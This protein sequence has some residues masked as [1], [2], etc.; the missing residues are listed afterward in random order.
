MNFKFFLFTAIL[1]G[2]LVFGSA[3][4][5]ES[6]V[7]PALPTAVAADP[8]YWGE[9]GFG[10]DVLKGFGMPLD[11]YLTP[12]V[13]ADS[14]NS[15][16]LSAYYEANPDLAAELVVP[17][18]KRAK[19]YIVHFSDGEF[20]QG[21]TV[22]SF[23]KFIAPDAFSD[24]VEFHL[25]GLPSKD[26][27]VFYEHIR[28]WFTRGTTLLKFSV[29]VDVVSLDDTI[30]QTW[31]FK[32]CSITNYAMLQ[33]DS[34]LFVSFRQAFIPEIRE[35]TSFSCDGSALHTE[36]QTNKINLENSLPTKQDSAQAFIVRFH[37]GAIPEPITFTTFSKFSHVSSQEIEIPIGKFSIPVEGKVFEGR[38]QFVLESLP[39]KDK[40]WLYQ[41]ADDW[42]SKETLTDP[43]DVDIEFVAGDGTIIQTWEYV[44]CDLLD[45]QIFSADSLLAYQFSGKV[46]TELRDISHFSCSGFDFNTEQNPSEIKSVPENP[47]NL[48]PDNAS[49]GQIYLVKISGGM[50]P[51]PHTFTTFSKFTHEYPTIENTEQPFLTKDK[52]KFTL[53]SL[54]SKDKAEFYQGINNWFTQSAPI[55]PADVQIDILAGDGTILRSYEYVKCDVVGYE[56]YLNDNF[57]AFKFTGQFKME[58]RN[59]TTFECDGYHVNSDQRKSEFG[60]E[61]TI[62]FVDMLPE[63]S[64][65]A[66]TN[67]VT[68]SSGYFE[69][70]KIFTTFSK[71]SP[72]NMF[73]DLKGATFT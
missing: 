37:D 23:S 29:V 1:V 72:G 48:A 42:L 14:P 44:D 65:R 12:G 11:P 66:Q 17:E 57:V 7:A 32:K 39:S 22:T 10:L 30:L 2:T 16:I 28:D 55:E 15:E 52:P 24:S 45:L 64:Q 20:T 51:E 60:G 26:K 5:E 3:F 38:P 70:P 33:Q 41:L 68:L 18:D 34:K 35:Q 49:R 50:V 67:I 8:F 73:D 69:S 4:A 62:T 47:L 58:L 6:K 9:G 36:Q 27:E 25:Q 21:I 19:N 46:V 63:N 53:E 56:P 43:I 71:F 13:T 54:P 31:E 40:E 61:Q 59:K